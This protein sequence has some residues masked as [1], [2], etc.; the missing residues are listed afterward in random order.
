MNAQTPHSFCPELPVA[1]SAACRAGA[2]LTIDLGA[3]QAN[4]RLLRTR[5]NGLDCAAVVKADAYG[6][7]AAQVAPALAAAGCR[8]FFVAHLEEGVALRQVLPDEEIFVLHGLPRDTEAEA[9]NHR[10]VPVLNT[11]GQVDAWARLA[12]SR[13]MVLPAVLHV[14]TGMARLGLAEADVGVLANDPSRL[15][16]LNLRYVMSHL[17]AAED[18]SNPSN[19]R[20]LQRFERLRT[21]LP[22]APASLANSSG[23]FLGAAFHFDLLR[24][25]A[26]LYGVAPVPGRANPMHPVVRLQGRV[27]QVSTVPTGTPVGYNGRFVADGS[28]RVAT[29]SVGYADGFPRTLGNHASAGC[30]GVRLPVIGAVSMDMITLDVSALPDNRLHPGALVDVIGGDADSLDAIAAKGGTI[31]YEI[32]TS[33]GTRYWRH[34][35]GAAAEPLHPQ[36]R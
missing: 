25:G 21:Q 27:L 32:L 13:G 18:Q 20:Q 30:D 19:T 33:L 4:F 8:R 1:Q 17:A 16:G 34:Y 7:G 23:V 14:D 2:V 9:L 31:A 11:L 36:S 28:M 29:V 12:R 22:P 10:L 26:A 24:P 15:D 35:A 3:I 6:L 5:A